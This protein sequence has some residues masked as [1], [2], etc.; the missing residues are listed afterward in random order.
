M[1]GHALDCAVLKQVCAVFE[2]RRQFLVRIGHQERQIELC[3][4]LLQRQRLEGQ[5]AKRNGAT[6]RTKRERR[7][8]CIVDR[9]RRL[10]RKHD[11]EQWRAAQVAVRLKSL[12]EKWKRELLVRES[13][14]SGLADFFE[15]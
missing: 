4:A 5:C 6:R 1:S 9:F 13:F 7:D 3:D 15:K 12:N 14:Q 10:Q 11:L 2:T 8:T